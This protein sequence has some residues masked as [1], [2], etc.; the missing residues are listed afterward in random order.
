VSRLATILRRGTSP[1]PTIDYFTEKRPDFTG[2]RHARAISAPLGPPLHPERVFL[3]QKGRVAGA[4][5]LGC[6]ITFNM[7]GRGSGG[8][9]LGLESIYP[10]M[11]KGGA[12]PLGL[13]GSSEARTLSFGLRKRGSVLRVV[14]FRDGCRFRRNMRRKRNNRTAEFFRLFRFFRQCQ[15]RDK[16]VLMSPYISPPSDRNAGRSEICESGEVS[17]ESS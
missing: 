9:Q 14:L 8:L 1:R 5:S 16:W 15:S 17:R 10:P 4:P 2:G 13:S 3:E 7:F 6:E 12:A 11:A